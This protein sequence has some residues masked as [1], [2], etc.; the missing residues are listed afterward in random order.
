MW[1]GPYGFPLYSLSGEPCL[2]N[3]S[4]SSKFILF[5]LHSQTCEFATDLFLSVVLVYPSSHPFPQV[6][7]TTFS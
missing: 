6:L 5:C 1:Y 7:S 4:F 2:D 3:F